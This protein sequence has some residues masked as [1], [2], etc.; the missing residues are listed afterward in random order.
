[1]YRTFAFQ[2]AAVV[3]AAALFLSG[4]GSPSAKLVP[5]SGKVTLDGQPLTAGQVTLYSTTKEKTPEST[6]GLSSGTVDSSG[7]Y[8]ILTAG[9]DGA[10]L[11]KYKVLVT[12]P[13]MPMEN[14]GS[15][16]PPSLPFSMDYGDPNKTPL[17]IDVVENAAPGA[18]DLKLSSK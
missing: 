5:V 13:M 9:K 15:K 3:C 14:A 16:G 11:G 10:P 1:M 17:N 8:K 2:V 12:P 18:Y 7:N 6:A 4:C